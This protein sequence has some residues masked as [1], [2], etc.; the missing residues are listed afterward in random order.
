MISKI[1]LIVRIKRIAMSFIKV[2]VFVNT[3]IKIATPINIYKKN[4]KYNL[5]ISKSSFKKIN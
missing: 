3:I 2:K 4:L 1:K 5:Y